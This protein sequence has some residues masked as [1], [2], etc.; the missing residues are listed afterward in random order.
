[1]LAL[2]SSKSGSIDPKVAAG[3]ESIVKQNPF[4]D[5][6]RNALL[7][8]AQRQ[9]DNV[10]VLRH[11]SIFQPVVRSYKTDIFKIF[12]TVV[13]IAAILWCLFSAT[14]ASKTAEK[15]RGDPLWKEIFN[16][17]QGFIRGHYRHK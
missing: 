14:P 9:G 6:A 17:F 11:K 2:A 10:A 13:I 12:L 16:S 8:L 15:P 5:G 1:L 4:D 7:N 3:L